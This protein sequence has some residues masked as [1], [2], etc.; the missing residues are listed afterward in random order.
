MKKIIILLCLLLAMP[1]IAKSQFIQNSSRSLFS[2]VKAFKENDAIMVLIMED[3]RAN[4]TATTQTGRDHQLSGGVSF[5]AAGTANTSI[6]AGINT[7]NDFAASGKTTR[8]E[9]I[10]SR[11]SA[12]VI[13]VEDN[14][15]LRIRGTRTTTIN[16]EQQQIIIE[17][18][19]RPVD[20]MSDNSIYSYNIM[21]MTLIIEGDGVVTETQEP[22]LIT[23]FL[24]WLF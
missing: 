1:V 22:G 24:R 18:I 7:G 4:N 3:T 6:D 21:D 23:K 17:G 10:R 12:K 15:N 19:V 2:D 11:L 9:S 14:G 13:E 8:Q 20:V 5:N 16:G